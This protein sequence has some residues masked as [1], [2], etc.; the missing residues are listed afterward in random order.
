[1]LIIT[2]YQNDSGVYHIPEN[3][4]PNHDIYYLCGEW[5]YYPGTLLY[6][7]IDTDIVR[8]EFHEFDLAAVMDSRGGQT[9]NQNFEVK[10]LYSYNDGSYSKKLKIPGNIKYLSVYCL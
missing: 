2:L 8:N 9:E 7:A 4:N 6:T 1:M 3:S 5:E 10:N